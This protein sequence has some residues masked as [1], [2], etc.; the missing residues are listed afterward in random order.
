MK[1]LVKE[2]EIRDVP[3]GP[4]RQEE[5]GLEEKTDRK[6][7]AGGVSRSYRGPGVRRQGIQ[8]RPNASGIQSHFEDKKKTVWTLRKGGQW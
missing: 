1:G 2:D 8:S 4:R 3:S 6:D 5:P 7:G